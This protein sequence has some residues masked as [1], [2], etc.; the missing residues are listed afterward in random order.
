MLTFKSAMVCLKKGLSKISPGPSVIL[1]IICLITTGCAL[2]K[3]QNENIEALS[4]TVLVGRISA[5]F[6]GKGPIIVAAYSIVQ[7]KREV[8]H[9]TVLHDSGEYELMVAKGDYYVFAYWDKNSNLIYDADEPAGQY[10]GQK[11]VTAPSG[12]VVGSINISIPEKIQNIEVP[13]GFEISSVKPR[14][15]HS[16]LAGAIIE[17]DDERFSEEYGSKGYWEGV[18][19]FKEFGGNIFFIEEYDPQKIPILFIHG[20]TGTP[21]GWKYFIDNIDRTRFQPWFFYYPSGSRIQSMSYLLLWKLQNLQSKYHFDQLYITA[22]SMGGLVARS[23]VVDHS[24]NFPYVQLLVSLATP[25]GGDGMAEYGVKQSP[26]VVP[27]WIDMQ[28]ESPF[29]QSLYRTKM[30]ETVSFYMFYGHRGNRNPFR[31]NNDRT[32]AFSSLLDR[33]AQSE[34]QMNYAFNEDHTSIIH[35]KEVLEQYN[36]IINTLA[37]NQG[38]SPRQLGGFLKIHFSYDYPFEGERSPPTLILQPVG[39][40]NAETVIELSAND[41]GRVLGPFPTGDYLATF[42]ALTATGE[43]FV[44]VT[45]ENNKTGELR[46]KLTRDNII[47]GSLISPLQ[48]EDWVAGMPYEANFRVKSITLNGTGIDRKLH[49]LEGE[50][51]NIFDYTLSRTD[52]YYKGHFIFFGLVPGEYELIIRVQGYKPFVKRCLVRPDIQL[53]PMLIELTPE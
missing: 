36:S 17:L 53:D 49:V 7:G 2:I 5:T 47:Y 19:F 44:P 12:G 38:T 13:F 6:P 1:L 27:C 25:W 18:S 31:S 21:K 23:F 22:H 35:S 42:G 24:A 50:D 51:D 33:R 16:R 46:Y 40:K 39:K 4:S 43:K 9:Y 14:K 37:E 10:G 41:N 30:P 28:P 15:L 34:A 8:A 45:I 52:L 32:I 29:I 3:L 20:A 26:A 11:M 48:S